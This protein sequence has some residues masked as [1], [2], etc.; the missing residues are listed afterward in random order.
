MGKVLK[1]MKDA[2]LHIYVKQMVFK[3]DIQDMVR[4]GKKGERKRE[5]ETTT[6]YALCF[7]TRTLLRSGAK[8][9]LFPGIGVCEGMPC[10][11][12]D[13]AP[14]SPTPGIVWR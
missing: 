13:T 7:P 1:Q 14:I 4:K 5:R 8:A 12:L 9:G 10:A 6:I 11:R 3:T 2:M